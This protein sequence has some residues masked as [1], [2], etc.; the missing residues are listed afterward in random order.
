MKSSQWIQFTWDLT[1]LTPGAVELPEHYRIAPAKRD[2]EKE[3]RKVISSSFK[4]DPTWN[5]AIQEVTQTVEA[6]LDHAMAAE[7][8]I[9]LAL[10]HGLRIIGAAVVSPNPIAENH[11]SP[12]PCILTEYRNRGF[13]SLLLEHALAV[14]RDAGL[15]RASTLAKENSPVTKFLY[16]KFNSRKSP[17]LSNPALVA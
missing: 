4:L 7:S 17:Q 13:G 3:L 1:A 9:F 16:P 12:G 11:L 6:W 10:R 8:S 14:A 2:E 5:P 15:P